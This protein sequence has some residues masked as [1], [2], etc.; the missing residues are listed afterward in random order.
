[1]LRALRRRWRLIALITIVSAGAGARASRSALP[2]RYEAS[3]RPA[4][5]QRRS[6]T[7]NIDPTEPPARP[8]PGARADRRDQPGARVARQGRAR[9]WRAA[10]QPALTVEE[11]RDRVELEP[12]G[13][14]DIVTH[15]RRRRHSAAG[16]AD[17]Q[18][19]RRRGRGRE[20]RRCAAEDPAGDRR[21]QRASSPRRPSGT[22]VAAE[23]RRRAEQLEVE[24][25]LETGEV[26][27]ASRPSRRPRTA[28]R[29]RFETPRSACCSGLIL[30][31]LLAILL[32]RFDRRVGERGRG[33][34]A[35]RGACDR[36]R[37]GGARLRLGA[38]AV[39][40]SRSSSCA[41]TCSSA[42]RTAST[43]RSPSRARCRATARARWR[44]G[45][46][47]RWR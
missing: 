9:G 16:G 43:A 33:R 32:Q 24:R 13:Q 25:Q 35:V 19:L 15:H 12:Q 37:A 44:R 5:P 28:L 42:T 3:R 29:S 1:M 46:P 38:R 4:L 21:D 39:H 23:L 2:D 7:P 11:L 26:E 22:P 30:G 18:R 41:R 40:R 20:P 6:P 45:S 31:S 34:R 47:R 8:Q 36:T 10:Q 27:I 14:A 17:R